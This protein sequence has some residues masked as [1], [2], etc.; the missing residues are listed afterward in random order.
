[1]RALLALTVRISFLYS[2]VLRTFIVI[3]NFFNLVASITPFHLPDLDCVR[4]SIFCLLQTMMYYSVACS[5][6][7]MIVLASYG[8]V[9]PADDGVKKY[10]Y[11]YSR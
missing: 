10:I 5:A 1:M 3:S 6:Q 2:T 8:P 4:S 9:F 7:R 11:E